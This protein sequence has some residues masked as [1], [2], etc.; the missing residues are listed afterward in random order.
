MKILIAEDDAVSRR[1]LETVLKQL[2][3]EVDSAENGDE[4]WKKFQAGSYPVVI[5]DWMMPFVDGLDFCRKIRVQQK[6]QY[7]YFILLT[8]ITSDFENYSRALEAGVDDFLNKPLNRN[9]IAMRLLV[10]QRI[11][12]FIEQM[13][14]LK[15][16]LPICSYCRKVRND[17]NYWQQI[18][19]YVRSHTGTDFS[20]GICPECYEKQ[21]KPELKKFLGDQRTK[22]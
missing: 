14:Q 11:T 13:G 21:V 3:Y 7:A 4:A 20:H 22:S 6:R 10:A 16:L 1:L 19:S 9:E 15:E 5:S 2:G 18:E 17:E 12:G 8:S